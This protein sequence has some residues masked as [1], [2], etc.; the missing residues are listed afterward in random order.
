M[1]SRMR[2]FDLPPLDE[3]IARFDYLHGD[4][5]RNRAHVAWGSYSE[6]DQ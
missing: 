2:L 5:L 6:R 4:E 3:S 1:A